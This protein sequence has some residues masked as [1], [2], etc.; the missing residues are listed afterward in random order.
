MLQLEE[1]TEISGLNIKAKVGSTWV[2]PVI[3]ANIGGTWTKVKKAYGKVGGTWQK[4]YEY[5]SVYT[6]AGGTHTDVDLDA[7]GLDRYHN[8]RIVIPSNATLIAS[9]TSAYALRTGTSHNATLTIQNN[10]KIYGRGG[11]GGNGGYRYPSSNLLPQSGGTGGRAVYVESNVTFDNNGTIAGGGGGAGGGEGTYVYRH[12]GGG[13]G[14]GGAPYGTG[15][16]G[17]SA[18]G[19]GSY[20]AA[21]GATA[22]LTTG[23]AGGYGARA[24]G[25]SGY[26]YGGSGGS[27]GNVGATGASG[28]GGTGV[29]SAGTGVGGTGAAGATYYNPNGYTI[30]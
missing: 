29:F 5:E 26:F 2:D 30:S 7:L 17:L 20:N 25:N 4:T 15:G 19:G 6:L 8:V 21:S 13:G 14:G 12:A 16:A 23:G 27:G 10:G 3:Q 11:N 24:T 1:L 9:S 22:A 18:N 28:N